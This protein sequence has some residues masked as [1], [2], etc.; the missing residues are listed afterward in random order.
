[1]KSIAEQMI[2]ARH[3]GAL[4]T[5][6]WLGGLHGAEAGVNGRRLRAPSTR[7][8]AKVSLSSASSL[9][10]PAVFHRDVPIIQGLLLMNAAA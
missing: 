4:A 3:D 10:A 9:M 2:G 6:L 1:M 7:V 8:L 5:L